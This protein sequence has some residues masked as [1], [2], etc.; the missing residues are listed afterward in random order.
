M[1]KTH[2]HN[3]HMSDSDR[4]RLQADIEEAIEWL[5]QFG[6][7]AEGGVTRLLYTPA[8]LAAQQALKERMG[9]TGL[10][11]YYDDAGNLFGRLQGRSVDEGVILT[12]SHVD[13]VNSGG[14]YDGAYGILAG[15]LAVQMLQETYGAPRRTIEVVSL[16]EEEGSRFP[17]TYWGSGNLTGRY[18]LEQTPDLADK[19]GATLTEAMEAAGFGQGLHRQPRRS[20]I[21]EFIELH[22]E[23]GFVLEKEKRTIGIVSGIVGQR[24]HTVKVK[25]MA[26]HAGTTP[27]K[28]RNDALTGACEMIGWLERK[29]RFQS[30]PFVSTVGQLHVQPNSSNV[31]PGQVSFTVDVRD[32]REER[33]TD[34]C[35]D[36]R[37]SFAEMAE[38][39][40]LLVEVEEWMNMAPAQ[41]NDEMNREIT[42]IC[43][44]NRLPSR[45]MFS[46]A[47]HDAQVLSRLCPT[48]MLFVPS[49]AGISHSPM[50]FSHGRDLAAGITVLAEWL[51]RKAY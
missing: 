31:I 4:S 27:M 18:S 46:G 45:T 49:R 25:G 44:A 35:R 1:G 39:R 51:Y 21:S 38:E 22:I 28:Y 26:N 9:Q 19:A 15:M 12:G 2:N 6:Q 11:T 10:L 24:R 3:L 33:L 13:T 41:M 42:A 50:E 40:G 30:E 36:F 43:D 48:T 14:K 34:F 37:Q 17:L 5:A 23:Q 29:A 47:G 20:D 8:W 16:C 7:E 32:S